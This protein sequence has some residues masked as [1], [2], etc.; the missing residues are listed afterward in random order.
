MTN[1]SIYG[2]NII[3]TMLNDESIEVSSS[4]I[5]FLEEHLASITNIELFL[6]CIEK[7]IQ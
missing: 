2:Y 7:C 6:G 1:F 5:D 3:L 4:V